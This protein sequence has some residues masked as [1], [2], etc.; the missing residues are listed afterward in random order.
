MGSPA[1]VAKTLSDED[2]AGI[3]DYADRYLKYKDMY[4]E[5]GYKKI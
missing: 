4:I 5:Q 3:R 2:I 1:K